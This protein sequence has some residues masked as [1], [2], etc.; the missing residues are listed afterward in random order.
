VC[1]GRQAER[2]ARLRLLR[3]RRRRVLAAMHLSLGVRM[4][5]MATSDSGRILPSVYFKLYHLVAG[6]SSHYSYITSTKY[7][8]LTLL[9]S[10][11]LQRS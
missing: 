10:T 5:E 4:F 1:S 9:T 11:L 2:S 3:G 8:R 6:L 7:L